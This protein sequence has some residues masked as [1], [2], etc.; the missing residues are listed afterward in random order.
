[1]TTLDVSIPVLECRLVLDDV[2]FDIE[3]SLHETTQGRSTYHAVA[4]VAGGAAAPRRAV[5]NDH[6][7]PLVAASTSPPSKAAS[8]MASVLRRRYGRGDVR[9][10]L[11]TRPH[12]VRSAVEAG[13]E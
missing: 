4:F 5:V 8:F 3:V 12:D 10:V 6:G 13:F 9:S 2:V 1:M 11:A 7:M